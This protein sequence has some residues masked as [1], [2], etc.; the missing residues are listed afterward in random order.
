LETAILNYLLRREIALI[1]GKYDSRQKGNRPK[2]RILRFVPGRYRKQSLLQKTQTK[3]GVN[4]LH[5]FWVA[6]VTFQVPKNAKCAKS[7]GKIRFAALQKRQRLSTGRLN[8][9]WIKTAKR[10]L[11][12]DD[13]RKL[14]TN[15]EGLKH[16][17]AFADYCL[18]TCPFEFYCCHG[19][20]HQR[21]CRRL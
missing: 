13:A 12:L 11:R 4:L 6:P 14:R 16:E 15:L 10:G 1:Q 21:H 7:E 18:R 9:S 3:A 20:K 2:A 5:S 8:L 17:G 19:G